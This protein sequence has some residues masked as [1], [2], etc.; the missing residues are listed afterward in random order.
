[1]ILLQ[2]LIKGNDK[3]LKISIIIPSLNES[4]N[5]PSLLCDLSELNDVSEI[6][7]IDSESKDKTEDI[8]SIYGTRFYKVKERNRGLQLNFGA[9][10]AKG[11]W[12]FF[13]HADSK[14][15]FNWSKEIKSKISR[16]SN[17]IYYFNFKIDNKLLKYRLLE[18]FVNLRCQFFKSPYGDQGILIHKRKYSDLGG[19]KSIPL[20]EDFDF[21]RRIKDRKNLRCLK[22]SIYT[23]S[24]KWENKNIIW[25]SFK[26]WQLRRLWLK[27]K[28]LNEIYK[29]YYNTK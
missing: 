3:E 10:K 9:E 18:L 15:K 28:P 2:T 11:E 7:I 23:N 4:Q 14:L 5:L 13:I 22:T 16:N 25:Q 1:M 29:I 19:F 8:A 17:Y 24:R 27:G 26:N 6:L 12:L 20:M 21:I